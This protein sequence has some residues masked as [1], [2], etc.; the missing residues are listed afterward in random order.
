[1]NTLSLPP[2][3]G[4]K[5]LCYGVLLSSR[6]RMR[7][8]LSTLSSAPSV[9]TI[10]VLSSSVLGTRTMGNRESSAQLSHSNVCF[11][12]LRQI[13]GTKGSHADHTAKMAL[14]RRMT[15]I[16]THTKAPVLANMTSTEEVNNFACL[17]AR[18]QFAKTSTQ[19]MP[20]RV[21]GSLTNPIHPNFTLHIFVANFS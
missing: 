21:G 9:E 20:F 15:D 4:A 10:L 1:M 3:R 8:E 2:Q 13:A 17:A 11:D 12:L 19:Q 6:T 18:L 5:R 16:N 7:E 14:R